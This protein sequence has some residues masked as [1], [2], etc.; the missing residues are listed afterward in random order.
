[1]KRLLAIVTLL[2]F[3]C[4][5]C[6]AQPGAA[7]QGESRVLQPAALHEDFSYLRKALEETHPGLY[8][9]H[10]REEMQHIMDSL[11]G[12]LDRPMAFFD[13]YKIIAHLIAEV[14]CEHTYSSPYGPDFNKVLTQWKL[15]PMQIEFM[16]PKAYVTVN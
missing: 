16:D 1:M 5:G 12:L 11:Y 3:L 4:L 15:L 7:D 8:K 14:K 6:A 2:F 9:H 13:F 10:S